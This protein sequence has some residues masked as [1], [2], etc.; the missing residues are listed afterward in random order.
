MRGLEPPMIILFAA[1]ALAAVPWL[2]A[3]SKRFGLA[4][5]VPGTAAAAILVALTMLLVS[6][7]TR[8]DIVATQV[9][10]ALIFAAVGALLLRRTPGALRKPG[11]H[12]VALWVAP[13]LGALGWIGTLVASQFVPGAARLS[14]AMNGDG[15]NNLFY[16]NVILSARGLALGQSE[17]PVPLPASLLA[18][19]M[20]PGRSSIAN[21][22]LLAHDLASFT[23]IWTLIFAAVCILTGAVVASLIPKRYPVLVGVAS[24]LGSLLPLTWYV[25]GLPMQWGYFNA[26]VVL[27]LLLS[28][29]L[30]FL[31]SRRF[32]I[33]ALVTI[34]GLTTL[35]LATWAP[36]VLVPGA[37]AIVILARDWKLI[38]SLQ[39]RSAVIIVIAAAQVMA[40]VAIVT[41]PTFLAQ[42]DALEIA[43]HGFPSA[44]PIVPVLLVA[45]VG[46]ALLTAR[47]T[48]F[49]VLPGMIAVVG[50]SVAASGALI[51]LDHG[52]GDP[53]TAYYPTK[54][55]WI[56]S[57]FLV[58]IVLSLALAAVR[59][60][61]SDGRWVTV[62]VAAVSAAVL[63]ACA[64]LPAEGPAETVVRQPLTRI[65][66]GSIWHTGDRAVSKILR[67]SDPR[68]PGILWQSGDPDE[69]MIDFWVLVTRG[70]DLLGDQELRA[71]AFVAYREYRATGT[72]DDSDIAPLCRIVT[73]ME[74]T[75]T[76]HTSSAGLEAHLRDACPAVTPR[77][78]VDER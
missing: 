66:T 70:G 27:P 50:S 21:R 22:D 16:G 19:A 11:R 60:L 40:W 43:G 48:P 46:L 44:W 57:V 34:S 63:L 49:P 53:W 1:L 47:K 20:A 12:A 52:Q 24:A 45:L 75:P 7:A 71:I 65:L 78:V 23:I 61:V 51:Y 13:M 58:I 8:W 64:A 4:I 28:T 74:S 6:H 32:P 3:L 54:L 29:W 59:A 14:W 38:R 42:G 76:V 77:V 68:D 10:G 26:N 56:L 69:A 62:G 36:L 17:N 35:V 2:L 25:A 18:L 73:L 72:F 33:A 15:F 67:L 41:V 5:A 30:V 31:A 39:G 55:A 9:G 37:L